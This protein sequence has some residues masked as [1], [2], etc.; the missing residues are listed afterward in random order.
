MK[1]KP[2][3]KIT[4]A[5]RDARTVAQY[6]GGPT[7]TRSVTATVVALLLT[8]CTAPTHPSRQ[9]AGKLVAQEPKEAAAIANGRH[10]RVRT[11][12][13][14]YMAAKK[15]TGASVAIAKDD[16]LD[17][18]QGFGYADLENDVVYQS[19]T[20]NRLASVSKTITAV[21]VMQLVE[22]GKIDLDADIRAYVPEFP[23]KGEQITAR[24]I[25]KHTSGIRHY[26]PDELEN[27]TRLASVVD[28][29]R[30][31]TADPLL[32][33]PG[34][35]FTYSTY[36]FSLLARAVETTSGLTFKDYLDQ[37]VFEPA[38]MKASGLE[39]LRAIV[40]HRTRGYRRRTDGSVGNSDFSDISYKW[41][42]GGMVSTSPD[43]CRFGIALLRGKLMAPSTLAQMWTVQKLNDGTALP[44]SLGWAVESYNGK[45]VA[46]HGGAQPMSRTFLLIVPSDNL[47][48][49]ILTNYESHDPQE[50]AIAVRDAWYEKPS[51]P[52]VR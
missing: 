39:D 2:E 13:E 44:Q 21:A 22:A 46:M 7:A 40:K 5:R 6:Q 25:L 32:H 14:K 9:E 36:A 45:A 27:Y 20:V 4:D 43:L 8:G 49:A 51:L 41:A 26:K 30:R 48:M 1:T 38:G 29:L 23:D 52:A 3:L 17:F 10:E 15:I 50:M 11:A 34:E 24:H 12:I 47:V 18:A 33:K 35:K 31:F 19:E 42:G 16:K 28:G 37:K